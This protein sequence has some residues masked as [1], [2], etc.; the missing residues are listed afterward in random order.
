MCEEIVLAVETIRC[1]K[2]GHVQA[3][4]VTWR[5]GDPFETYMHQC[6]CCGYW[7]HEQEWDRMQD[8]STSPAAADSVGT[9]GRG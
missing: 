6:T 2:C 9:S 3:A 5:P 4:Q 1:P 7:I 8:A